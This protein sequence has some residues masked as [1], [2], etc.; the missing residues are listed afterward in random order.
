MKKKTNPNPKKVTERCRWHSVVTYV[1]EKTLYEA[2]RGDCD[3]DQ[4]AM[5]YHDKD[6]LEDGS[7]KKPHC[8][9][10]MRFEQPQSCE[11]VRKRFQFFD[12]EARPISFLDQVVR[13][14]VKALRYLC[15]LDDLD[16]TQY[17]PDLVRAY[18]L[19]YERYSEMEHCEGSHSL[20]NAVHEM[21]DGVSVLELVDR[22]GLD[23]IK[24]YRNIEAIVNRIHGERQIVHNKEFLPALE[25]VLCVSRETGEL[26]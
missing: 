24:N 17:S 23:F 7:P 21:A 11:A 26:L 13:N 14:K 22:Y 8:H 18:R 19:N 6:V 4:F 5:I 15:H 25:E 1:E 9:V 10:V 12:V 16:K 2:L 3:I 20:V